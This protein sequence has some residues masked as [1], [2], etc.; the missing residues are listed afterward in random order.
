LSWAV[1]HDFP[2]TA[3]GKDFISEEANRVVAKQRI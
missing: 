2:E 3:L 1:E